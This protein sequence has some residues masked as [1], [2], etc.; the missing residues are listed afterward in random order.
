MKNTLFESQEAVTGVDKDENNAII[1]KQGQIH[2][3]SYSLYTVIHVRGGHGKSVGL[4]R[5]SGRFGAVRGSPLV[6][7]E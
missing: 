6:T 5:V 2:D 7:D 4:G 3:K 1:V